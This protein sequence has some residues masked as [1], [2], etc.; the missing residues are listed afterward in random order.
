M[1]SLDWNLLPA[2]PGA[3]ALDVIF[4]SAL[5]SDKECF[6]VCF[7]YVNLLNIFFYVRLFDILDSNAFGPP[8]NK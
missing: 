1:T 7:L 4:Y 6:F 8:K 5:C 2:S 3:L